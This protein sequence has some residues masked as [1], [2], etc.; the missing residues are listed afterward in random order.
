MR[1]SMKTIKF[2]I[3]AVLISMSLAQ[4]LFGN[5]RLNVVTTTSD[6]AYIAKEVGGD[7]VKVTNLIRGYQDP[8]F[9]DPR[10]DYIVKLNR[11]DVFIQIG[12]DLEIGWAPV[13]IRQSRNA[14]ILMNGPGYCDASVGVRVLEIPQVKADRSQ[15]DIHAFGNP[16]YW[17]DPVNAAIVARN[18]RT[19]YNRVDPAGRKY[20]NRQY[21]KFFKKMRVLTIREYR[22]FKPYRGLKVAV[23][24]KEFVYL[25][26]RFKFRVIKPIEEK[27]G[28]PP[29]ANYLK[30]VIDTIRREKIK[31]ILIAPWNNPRYARSV[32]RQTGA[33]LLVMP[34]CVNS[35]SGINS[36]EKMITTMLYRLRKAA[37]GR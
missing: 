27:P 13:L 34:V 19:T 10:P 33:R 30:E 31:I 17:P 25:A 28:V 36:Y 6:L 9:I 15:G 21:K 14:K 16:H 26:H 22:K 37:S 12:L 7:R 29:S 35:E 24:H 32:A 1:F 18:I 20:Y 3:L 8:H 2:S 4:P 5:R 11:A 23:Y